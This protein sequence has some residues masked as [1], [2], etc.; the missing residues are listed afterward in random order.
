MI[1]WK[2]YT[3]LHAEKLGDD[4]PI[5]ELVLPGNGIIKNVT[6]RIE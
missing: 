6:M 1:E 5:S 3:Q 2:I 4:D